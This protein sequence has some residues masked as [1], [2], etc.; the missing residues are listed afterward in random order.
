MHTISKRIYLQ[1]ESFDAV[2]VCLA[3]VTPHIL[4]KDLKLCLKKFLK[5][6]SLISSVQKKIKIKRKQV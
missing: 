4:L 6:F 5:I 1:S 2:P 3:P